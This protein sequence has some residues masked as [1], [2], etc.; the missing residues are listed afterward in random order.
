MSCLD[1]VVMGC[2]QSDQEFKRMTIIK[3][4]QCY[5]P[6]CLLLS[7]SIYKLVELASTPF[8]ICLSFLLIMLPVLLVYYKKDYG[9]LSSFLTWCPTT[10]TVPVLYM[11]NIILLM[12]LH[13]WII[14]MTTETVAFY[15]QPNTVYHKNIFFISFGL[16]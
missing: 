5:N 14:L 12:A 15:R 10:R 3:Y 7:P 6:A 9:Q 16:L 13:T 4:H 8:S 2:K 1:S 11:Y